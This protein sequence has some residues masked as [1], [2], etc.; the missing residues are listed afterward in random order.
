AAGMRVR[1]APAIVDDDTWR[2]LQAELDRR[3]GRPW[4]R[5]RSNGSLL[6]R[7]A[8]CPCGL[9]CYVTTGRSGPRYRCSSKPIGGATCGHPESGSV[10]VAWLDSH[11][12]AWFLGKFGG[13]EVV[14]QVMVPG[15][16][17][18]AERAEVVAALDRLVKR[19]E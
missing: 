18:D 1:R 11:V 6:L 7:I 12:T 16:N 5:T 2:R 8:Y 14:R 19:W 9:R 15:E 3:G 10:E 13:R 17:T 4:E